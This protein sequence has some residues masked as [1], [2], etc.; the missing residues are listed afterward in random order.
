M[1]YRNDHLYRSALLDLPGIFHGFSTREGGVSRLPHTASM[2]AAFFRGDDDETVRRNLTILAAE[3]S[4]L[5]E[6]PSLL[7]SLVCGPQVHGRTVR[8][9]GPA[10]GGEGILR[11]SPEPCDGYVTADPGVF[12]LIRVADCVPV[13]LAGIGEDGTPV[14]GAVHAGWRGTVAGI[15]A[16]A[17]GAMRDM[18]AVPSAIRAALG[19]SIHACCYVVGEDFREAVR[20]ARGEA[21][22]ARHVF[23]D[24]DR[25]RADLQ[26]MNLEILLEAGLTED[27]VDVSP[28]CTCC[29]PEEF[30]SH[31]ATG[32]RRGA[33]GA[34]IG[35]LPR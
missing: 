15:C 24:G 29:R 31:R 16:A 14:V 4:G 18:G 7:S 9:V 10:N 20:A 2:N 6:D 33:M 17:V 21:F 27:A 19:P 5:P 26:S 1:F 30:H 13:L 28:A 25:L 32:G 23:R 11:D 34:V 12:P 22:A 3:A 35:I 8:R